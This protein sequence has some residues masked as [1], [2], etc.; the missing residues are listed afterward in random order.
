MSDTPRYDLSKFN[1]PAAKEQSAAQS[2]EAKQKPA[3][4]AKTEPSA[5]GY[6]LS[7]FHL[8]EVVELPRMDLKEAT[9][10]IQAKDFGRHMRGQ[11]EAALNRSNQEGFNTLFHAIG[12]AQGM[13]LMPAPALKR[14]EELGQGFLKS[15]NPKLFFTTELVSFLNSLTPE[16]RK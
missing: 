9:E 13:Q 4:A 12:T 16:K 14:F 10:K 15:K 3:S 5:T 1:L 7:S 6:D 2:T 11:V 8:P